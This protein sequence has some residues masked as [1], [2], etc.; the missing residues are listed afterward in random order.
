MKF[1]K[2]KFVRAASLCFAISAMLTA[3]CIF[4]QKPAAA[5]PQQTEAREMAE[6]TTTATAPASV[7]QAIAPAP[8][9]AVE[10]IELPKGVEKTI[11][12]SVVLSGKAKIPQIVPDGA[13]YRPVFEIGKVSVAGSGMAN[14]EKLANLGGC[15]PASVFADSEIFQGLTE[16]Q[17]LALSEA[18]ADACKKSG[19]DFLLAPKY[20]LSFLSDGKETS[21]RCIAN[22][23]PV[24]IVGFEKIP[25]NNPEADALSKK[26]EEA[27]AT[28]AELQEKIE[29]AKT[30]ESE[31]RLYLKLMQDY[32]IKTMD[33]VRIIRALMGEI[34]PTDSAT[35]P[36][37]EPPANDAVAPDEKP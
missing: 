6:S 36:A 23:F 32:G 2:N 20:E 18:L 31:M 16:M 7:S 3:G 25:Q 24:K 19:A 33:D 27:N 5:E 35:V 14:G 34:S 30:R 37:T 22:G 26:L 8:A 1:P 21:V 15:V 28:I 29:N 4:R 11:A 17:R 13:E 10:N 9:P 12:S